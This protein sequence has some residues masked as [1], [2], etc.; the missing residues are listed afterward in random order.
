[1]ALSA[2]YS[3]FGIVSPFI[4]SLALLAFYSQCSIVSPFILSIAL[5][6]FNGHNSYNIVIT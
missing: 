2:F 5:L 6:A 4:L 3:Q 1:M